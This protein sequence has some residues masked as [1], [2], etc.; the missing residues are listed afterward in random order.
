MQSNDIELIKDVENLKVE[1]GILFDKYEQAY[2]NTVNPSANGVVTRDTSM[3]S[4]VSRDGDA[5]DMSKYYTKS[6]VDDLLDDKAD[7]SAVYDKT[8][9][10]NRITIDDLVNKKADAGTVYSKE[11]ITQKIKEVIT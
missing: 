2:N 5:V 4:V 11:E 9:S 7:V 3:N 8:S 10:Y 6:E 1:V